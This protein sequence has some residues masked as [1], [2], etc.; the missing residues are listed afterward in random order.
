MRKANQWRSKK[1]SKTKV[2]VGRAG[3]TLIRPEEI[4]DWLTKLL[5]E[6]D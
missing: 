6:G 4:H 5:E 1:A 2:L 3:A